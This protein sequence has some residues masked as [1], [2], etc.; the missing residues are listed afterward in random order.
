MLF[1]TLFKPLIN[2][3]SKDKTQS[4]NPEIRKKA[5]Q[6]LPVSDQETLNTIA[7][8]DPDETIRII[9]IHKI[10]NLDTLQMLIMK[11]TNKTAKQAAEQRFYQL[12]CGLKHP[13]PEFSKREKIILNSRDSNL[14]EFVAEHADQASLRES[15]IKKISRD[16]LL[17]N[18]ALNDAHAPIRQLA[19]EQITKRSTLERVAKKSR[20]KDK[21]VYKIIHSKLEQLIEDEERPVLLAKEVLDICDKLE[22]L[23]KRN[24]LLQEKT[25]FENYARRWDEIKNFAD[26]DIT[27][28]Y[29]TIC[30]TIRHDILELEKK[31]QQQKDA[32]LTLDDLLTQLSQTVDEHLSIEQVNE[33]NHELIDSNKKTMAHLHQEWDTVIQSISKQELI[34]SYQAKF[35]TLLELTDTK[36]IT[37]STDNSVEKIENIIEQAENMLKKSGFILEKTIFALQDRF[38]QQ[39]NNSTHSDE[40]EILQ[41][42]FN[43]VIKKLDSQLNIQQQQAQA[44][45][46]K[47]I[48]STDKIKTQ[49][50]EGFVSDAEGLLNDELKHI[51]K[52]T[53]ISTLEKQKFQETLKQLQSQLGNLSSWRNWAHGNE[54][55]N[56]VGKAEQLLE[57]TK[58]SKTLAEDYSEVTVTI[59]ELRQQWKKMRSHTSEELWQQFNTACNSVYEQCMPFIDQQTEQRQE[60]LKSKQALCEQ[61]ENYISNMSWPSDK[62]EAIDTSIDWIQVDKITRQARKEWSDIGYVERKDHKS[63]NKRFDQS[64]EIIRKELKTVWQFNQEQYFNLISQVEAL[65]KDLD[66]DLSGAI[67]KAK[68]YQKQWKTLGPVSSYQRNKLWRKFRK[69]CDVIF[70]KRQEEIDQKNNFNIE[71]LKEKEAICENLEALNQQ[72]LG[73]SDLKNA[74]K[75]IDTLWI[76]LK[77]QAK[78][79]SQDV[80]KRYS[81]AVVNYQTKIDNLLTEQQQLNIETLEKKADLC[82]QIEQL[83]ECNEETHTQL[84]EQWSTLVKQHE[85]DDSLKERFNQALKQVSADKSPLIKAEQTHKLDFCL[86]YEI[87]LGQ[88]SPKEYQQARMEKQVELLN[89]NLGNNSIE[90]DDTLSKGQ[91]SSYDLQILWYELSN[92]TQDNE[93]QQRFNQLITK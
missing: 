67:N 17:G 11:G 57:Q 87:L 4:N 50:E 43:T 36:I 62:A 14:L 1:D 72:P 13:I 44:F 8:N 6:N 30:T 35:Q 3:F 38:K 5:V 28:R 66:D 61:L 64:I 90:T 47:L 16:P 29:N 10:S 46:D 23:H 27:E 15:T 68:N 69:G 37:P 74:Y 52:S 86:T 24:L 18:I 59:K 40:V 12:L 32:L 33:T 54:R 89:S 79:L 91:D 85:N 81:S 42:R 9:A 34:A 39:L 83:S 41:N 65:H 76:E 56:L 19:A 58:N 70:A 2:T 25:T 48:Q 75:D 77:T 78:A 21:R 93:L 82:T 88:E 31:Q 55:E 53:L 7:N 60:N 20:R 45:K 80:N 26:D 22:K 51:K 63:I 84:N 49:L 73:L 92:Y 71:K